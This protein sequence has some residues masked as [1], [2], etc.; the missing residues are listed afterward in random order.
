MVVCFQTT[1]ANGGNSSSTEAPSARNITDEDDIV[2]NARKVGNGSIPGTPKVRYSRRAGDGKLKFDDS[3]Y[4]KATVQQMVD[5]EEN[6]P[7]DGVTDI[8]IPVPTAIDPENSLH[9]T[10]TSAYE[11]NISINRLLRERHKGSLA[12]MGRLFGGKQKAME[13]QKKA[14]ALMVSGK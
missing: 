4:K 5:E 9:E 7:P 2:I 14:E 3:F 6:A 11:T 10:I 1:L 8:Y 12:A 13:A